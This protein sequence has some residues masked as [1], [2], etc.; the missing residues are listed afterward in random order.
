M[1]MLYQE[2]AYSLLECLNVQQPMCRLLKPEPRLRGLLTKL[3]KEG[4]RTDIIMIVV[5]ERRHIHMKR[6]KMLCTT[7]LNKLGRHN[8]RQYGQYPKNRRLK[9]ISKF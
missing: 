5:A 4:R 1:K 7:S 6:H 8:A 2:E 3:P 9:F